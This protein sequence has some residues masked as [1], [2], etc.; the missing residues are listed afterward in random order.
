LLEN[1]SILTEWSHSRT[2]NCLPVDRLVRIVGAVADTAETC[3]K[4]E[5]SS[6]PATWRI[7]A[8]QTAPDLARVLTAPGPVAVVGCGT[9]WFVAQAIAALRESAGYGPTDAYTATEARLG[10]N[11]PELLVVSRSGTTTEVA[12]LLGRRPS[13]SRA[14]AVVAVA[15]TPVANAADRVVMLDYA[16]EESVV[17][18][19][20][21]TTLLA[22]ARAALGHDVEVL[23][24]SAEAALTS[25]LPARALDARQ[26][27]FLGTDW[28]IG[29]A[30]EAALKLREAA[31]LW[32]ESYPA[33]EYRHGP[34]ALAEPGTVVWI[35]GAAPE[36]LVA[37]VESTG[38][39]V[40]DDA[41]DPMVDLVRVHRLAL[42]RALR[43][44][45]DP[46]RPR[47][48]TRS[49]VLDRTAS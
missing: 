46:D 4:R 1:C 34:L 13:G 17:Q 45:L 44:G 40:V 49:V 10:R 14:T 48:L 47:N 16:D 42:T 20:F 37:Q 2:R 27:V 3:M 30:H 15:G 23:A 35:L 41:L 25:A 24:Q 12:D 22:A 6:Q 32:S 5:V 7:A 31:Q 28:S 26:T 29:L 11:Y 33:M 43:L 38:A 19:R 39:T 9:S 36:G 8:R 21:A 18:T